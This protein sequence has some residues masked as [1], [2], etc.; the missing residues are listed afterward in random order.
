MSSFQIK[1]LIIL[2]LIAGFI[3]GVVSIIPFL[4]VLSL[5]LLMLGVAPLVILLLIMAGK[6]DL[7]TV[8]DSIIAGAV[9]GFSANLTFAAAF[10][11][12]TVILYLITG[13]NANIFLRAVIMQSPLWLLIVCIIFIGVVTA[14]TNAFTGF[15][16]Y[17]MINFIRDS[18]A[19]KHKND[20][21]SM[22][23]NGKDI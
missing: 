23:T 16:T 8:K 2:S 9:T 21:F 1:N 14:T 18:Y 19:K 13:Y 7:T 6:F 4:G 20:S 22:Y 17:Y 15:L 12:I 11:I 10:S 5:F 3:L